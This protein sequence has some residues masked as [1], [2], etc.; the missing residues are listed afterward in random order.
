[1][2]PK[3]NGRQTDRA[4]WKIETALKMSRILIQYWY[5]NQRYFYTGNKIGKE[6]Y[7]RFKGRWEREGHGLMGRGRTSVDGKGKDKC[8]WE[9]EGQVYCRW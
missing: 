9:G 1:M 4:T 5:L 7:A 2:I 8:R 6:T 3:K